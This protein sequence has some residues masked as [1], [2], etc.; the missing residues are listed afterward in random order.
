MTQE[1]GHPESWKTQGSRP[2]EEA[3]RQEQ[4][5]EGF[6]SKEN[7][8]TDRSSHAFDHVKITLTGR[9]RIWEELT[10]GIKRLMMKTRVGGQSSARKDVVKK[11]IDQELSMC[12][13]VLRG[14]L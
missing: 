10:T 12:L 13:A 5:V 3:T 9:D 11:R 4:R 2:Q 8:R 14:G 6:R 7:K 1:R